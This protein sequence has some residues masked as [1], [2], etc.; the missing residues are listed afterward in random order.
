MLTG[1]SLTLDFCSHILDAGHT[2]GEG[3]VFILSILL[4]QQHGV[5][6]I[7]GGH[8][9]EY[10]VS[11]AI[12]DWER[13]DATQA[14][15][16]SEGDTGDILLFKSGTDFRRFP[17]IQRCHYRTPVVMNVAFTWMNDSDCLGY[18]RISLPRGDHLH[19]SVNTG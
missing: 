2:A 3:R 14:N 5:D 15:P 13:F 17:Q 7:L 8:D 6:L 10:Y 19:F 9:H 18:F 16:C 11:K 12:T 1:V 4:W